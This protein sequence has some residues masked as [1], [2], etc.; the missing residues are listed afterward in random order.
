V[1]GLPD[2]RLLDPDQFRACFQRFMARFAEA[3]QGVLPV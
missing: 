1:G 2:S 3:A